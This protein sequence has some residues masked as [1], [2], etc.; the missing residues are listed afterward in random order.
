[1]ISRRSKTSG[2]QQQKLQ[3]EANEL[4]RKTP[5]R[6]DI[7]ISKRG[8]RGDKI[9]QQKLQQEAQ[10]LI[11]KSAIRQDIRITKRGERGDKIY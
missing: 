4:K 11:Q 8:N 9:A 2:S 10:E 7:R 5:I 6:Q 1:M 3:H